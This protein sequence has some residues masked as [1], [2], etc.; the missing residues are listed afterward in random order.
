VS[1]LFVSAPD[2]AFLGIQAL[3]LLIQLG[4][5][6]LIGTYLAGLAAESGA[7]RALITRKPAT[8]G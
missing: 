5:G 2:G 8:S 6:L 7:R 3:A 1:G 4:A